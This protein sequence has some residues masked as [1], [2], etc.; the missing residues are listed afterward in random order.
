MEEIMNFDSHTECHAKN[1]IEF[2]CQGFSFS[3]TLSS[4]NIFYNRELT[5]I[6]IN[7][8]SKLNMSLEIDKKLDDLIMKN[9]QKD[10]IGLKIQADLNIGNNI[11]KI[12]LISIIYSAL[13]YFRPFKLN[14]SVFSL[15]LIFIPFLILSCL[16]EFKNCY[17]KYSN[18]LAKTIIFIFAVYIFTCSLTFTVLVIVKLTGD[19]FFLKIHAFVYF[20]PVF[21]ILFVVLFFW[22]FLYQG[23]KKE[24]ELNYFYFVLINIIAIC[25]ISAVIFF[26]VVFNL[27]IM[28][29]IHILGLLS[30]NLLVN[31]II[32]STYFNQKISKAFS[33]VEFDSTQSED[34][35]SV[36]FDIL[37][38]L[39]LVCF[40]CLVGLYLDNKLEKVKAH[41]LFFTSLLFFSLVGIKAFYKNKKI[42]NYFEWKKMV[43]I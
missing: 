27:K 37:L 21:G 24:N 13:L 23:Y 41:T 7:N 33:H 11:I 17:L 12:C 19:E 8:N 36:V 29:W 30:L 4:V 25:L 2:D 20:I 15:I 14:I 28:S 42:Q 32:F 31:L 22:I 40:L 5:S 16:L 9:V 3:D 26:K 39:C 43:I 18:D 6:D 10:I 35:L 38:N 34:S 1:D